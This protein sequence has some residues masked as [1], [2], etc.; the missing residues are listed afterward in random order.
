MNTGQD[1]RP[2][3]A[4]KSL[5][6]IL[7][8]VE[9]LF[10]EQIREAGQDWHQF[11][12]RLYSEW[13]RLFVCLH[14]L[15]GWQYDFFYT[16]HRILYSLV[17]YWL[18]R[19]LELKLLD[20]KQEA[21]PFSYVS[22]KMV[23][24]VLYVDLFSDNLSRLADHI[25]Y[26]KKLGL[27]YLHLMPLYTVPH[28]DNDGGYAVSDYRAIN[29]DIGSMD[30]LAR[31]TSAL[32][33]EEISLALDFVFNHTS[34]EHAWAEKAKTGDPD[35]LAYYLTFPDR[36]LP[37]QF[38][39][40]LR[41][42]FPTV[43]KG[44]FTWC[45]EMNRWVWTTFNSYQWDLNYANAEVFRSMA[46][47]M[48]FL[49]NQGVEVLRLDAVAFIWK[50]LGTNCENQP[51]AHTIIRAFNAMARIAA[52]CMTFK[53][54][55]IVAPDEVV[56]YIHPDE[57][58]LSYNPLLMALLWEALA[59]QET[60][61]LDHSMRK[62][63]R[64]PDG[65]AW[66]NYIRCHDDIGWTFDDQDAKEVGIDPVGHRKFL[67]RFYTGEFPGSFARGVP[68]QFNADTGDLRISGTL[69]SLA[70]LED[71]LSRED[72]DLIKRA[73]HRVN[74]LRSIVMSIGGIPLLYIGDE[75]GMLNDY[76]YLSDPAKATDSRWVHRS[77]KRW[78]AREDLSDQETLEWRFFQDMVKLTDLRKNIPAFQNGGMEVIST[79][80]PHLFGY[81]RAFE[82]QKIMIINNFS[83]RSQKMDGT[84]LTK[85][86]AKNEAVNLLR[87]EIIPI[88]GEFLLGEYQ[89]MWLDIS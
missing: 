33:D 43:R 22:E 30:D 9:Q 44:S 78:E 52:P 74:L 46:E 56:R 34:D 29:P 17:S 23:G 24:G 25:P 63:Y 53:S 19:P 84:V 62:R 60:K 81:I 4:R 65:C 28:G 2:E 41:D 85:Y 88:G 32:R 48:L 61:L 27:T 64:I 26:F 73:V 82:D 37:D 83:D 6:R 10:S 12:H 75:W 51:E 59:T 76:T 77:R 8:E 72:N 79:G 47:E 39:R 16:L 38:Q 15:Y 67:N 50:R 68:F 54:E 70:G 40:Y 5:N 87:N 69:S 7:P 57:C 71:A 31:L 21:K 80:N 66:V 45:E 18:E 55:A 42:I 20:A 13:E 58:Q 35:F 36:E 49:A 86:G 89:P 11:K 14:H 1:W 3:E